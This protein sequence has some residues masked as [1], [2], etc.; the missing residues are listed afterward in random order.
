MIRKF[1]DVSTI[2]LRPATLDR[3]NSTAFPIHLPFYG[4]HTPD[5]FFAY[6]DDTV[7]GPS[8]DR[9]PPDIWKVMVHARSLGC[10]YVMFDADGPEIDALPQYNRGA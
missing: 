6:V 2:H 7:I 8:G 4:G 1:L 10:E 9:I 5:G 3:I